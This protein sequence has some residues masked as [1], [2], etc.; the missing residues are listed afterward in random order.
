MSV[1][2]LLYQDINGRFY[3]GYWWKVISVNNAS[4]LSIGDSCT[5]EGIYGNQFSNYI[6]KS[7]DIIAEA[8]D[9]EDLD[10]KPCILRQDSKYGFIDPDG[11]WYGCNYS[12]HMDLCRFVLKEDNPEEYGWVKV[13][14]SSFRDPD[15]YSRRKFLTEAQMKTLYDKGFTD[16][17][18]EPKYKIGDIQ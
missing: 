14:K 9:W 6:V 1:F 4:Q 13:Y 11:N 10:W 5:I 16:I 3:E 18:E 12:D 7:G 8:N 2:I 15:Y 17:Y